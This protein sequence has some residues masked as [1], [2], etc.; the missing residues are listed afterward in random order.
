MTWPS[1]KE[2]KN[3]FF[4]SGKSFMSVCF[5][6]YAYSSQFSAALFIVFSSFNARLLKSQCLR[7]MPITRKDTQYVFFTKLLNSPPPQIL[8][9]WCLLNNSHGRGFFFLGTCRMPA[10]TAFESETSRDSR[11]RPA[12]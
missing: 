7:N 12:R 11:P 8:D 4:S 3:R 6:F 10:A 5:L 1:L 2:A 9:N